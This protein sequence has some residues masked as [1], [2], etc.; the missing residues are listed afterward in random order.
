MSKY[1]DAIELTKKQW[2][3]INAEI[4]AEGDGKAVKLVKLV[5]GR[6]SRKR[7]KEELPKLVER[8]VIRLSTP[9]ALYAWTFGTAQVAGKRVEGIP[10]RKEAKIAISEEQWEK[11]TPKR[12]AD[13]LRDTQTEKRASLCMLAVMWQRTYK[14]SAEDIVALTNGRVTIEGVKA[15]DRK[16]KQLDLAALIAGIE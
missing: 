7:C 8:K 12:L 10:G 6:L 4:N 3:E 2:A 14:P 13:I 11:V 16:R 5:D 15:P 9:E 1:A